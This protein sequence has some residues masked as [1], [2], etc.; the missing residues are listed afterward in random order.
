MGSIEK[1]LE[2]WRGLKN[3]QTVPRDE[4]EAVLNRYFEGRWGFPRG[5]SSH[6]KIKAKGRSISI[7]VVGQKVYGFYLKRILELI[8]QEKGG[9]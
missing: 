2:R 7:A 6:I 9:Q 5:G 8:A 3:S 1:K 4:V